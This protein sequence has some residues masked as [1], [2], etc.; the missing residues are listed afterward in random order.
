[1][2]DGQLWNDVRSDVLRRL[3]EHAP[4]LP[5]DMRAMLAEDAAREVLDGVR[6]CESMT[7]PDRTDGCER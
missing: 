5:Y 2:T 4:T 6:Y 3:Q 7:A 1:M